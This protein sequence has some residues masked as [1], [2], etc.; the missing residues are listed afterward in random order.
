MN[1]LFVQPA[2]PHYRLPF[3]TEL[4][5][6]GSNGSPNRV[7]VWCDFHNPLVPH[8]DSTGLFH[9]EHHPETSVGPFLWRPAITA[10]IRDPWAEVVVLT[11]NIRYVQLLPALLEARARHRAVVLWGHGYS[12]QFSRWRHV[13]RTQ[14]GKLASTCVTYSEGVRRRLI[15]EGLEAGRVFSAPNALDGAPLQ[16]LRHYWLTHP[17]ELRELRQRFG[18]GS[19][20]VLLFV[21]RLE[22]DKRVDLLLE[23][24][25]R[26]LL[27]HQ[28]TRLVIVGGGSELTRL[29]A[30]AIRLGV[31]QQTHF[32]GPLYD[33]HTLSG[34]FM[35]ATAFVYPVAVGLSILHALHYGVPVIT[36]NNA[37]CHNPEFDVLTHERNSLLYRHDD[38]SDLADCI[39]RLL[40]QPELQL[41][42][43]EAAL[44]SVSGPHGRTLTAMA[45]GML[46]ALEAAWRFTHT[47]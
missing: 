7:H 41:R 30:E 18:L 10:A 16:R 2:L 1:I 28:Y 44:E 6:L 11:W 40:E 8:C 47:S 31:D 24:F 13:T 26:L 12:K 15:E 37:D 43:T 32:L 19:E 3:F 9:S 33:E 38:A 22:P 45:E 39:A 23:A 25:Q 17:T 5:R 21:S 29:K 20:R 46:E 36:S 27:R 4:Q 42:L 35:S 34:L 14:L